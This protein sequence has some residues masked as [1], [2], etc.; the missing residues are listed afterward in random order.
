MLK[1]DRSAI[2]EQDSLLEDEEIHLFINS[3][4]KSKEIEPVFNSLSKQKSQ[5]SSTMIMLPKYINNR[6]NNFKHSIVSRKI[7]S[8]TNLKS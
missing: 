5:F 7:Q 4:K 8:R 6:T 2:I 3:N 1:S